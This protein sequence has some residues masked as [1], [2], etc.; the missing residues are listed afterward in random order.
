MGDSSD[1]VVEV[2]VWDGSKK[3]RNPF[4]HVSTRILSGGMPYSYSLEFSLFNNNPQHVCNTK[5]FSKVEKKEQMEREGIGFILNLTAE[6]AS[7]IYKSM[8]I[9]FHAYNRSS[10]AYHTLSHNCTFAIQESIERSGIDLYKANKG[11]TR[12][13]AKVEYALLKT[14]NNDSRLVK[15]IIR[16]PKGLD[17]GIP[18]TENEATLL[19]GITALHDKGGWS[20]NDKPVDSENW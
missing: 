5:P 11:R 14:M 16:Y 12:L 13:P 8:N 9:R 4:G 15:S 17:K 6:Q 7:T 10:C 2:I 18:I 20:T 19:F 3:A 1:I